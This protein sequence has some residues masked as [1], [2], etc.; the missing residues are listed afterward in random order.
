MG[1]FDRFLGK[2]NN[3]KKGEELV[4]KKDQPEK[5]LTEKSVNEVCPFEV[6][7][8]RMQELRHENINILVT[9]GVW[10][11][12]FAEYME[13][14]LKSNEECMLILEKCN[15]SK[16]IIDGFQEILQMLRNYDNNDPLIDTIEKTCKTMNNITTDEHYRIKDDF[17][18]Q[19]GNFTSVGNETIMKEIEK[20]FRTY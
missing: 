8:R 14:M 17:V 5:H 11:R 20:N 2:K 12:D 6:E 19:C 16:E 18:R 13:N 10:E 1:I 15:T 9:K 4:I 7:L 3:E